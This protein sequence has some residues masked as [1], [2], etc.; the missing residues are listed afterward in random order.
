MLV[1][2]TEKYNFYHNFHDENLKTIEHIKKTD[3][4]NSN[5]AYLICLGQL[6]SKGLPL[7][8][9]SQKRNQICVCNGAVNPH[10][11]FCM[12]KN[13]LVPMVKI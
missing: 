7:Y 12:H 11:K 5:S 9:L 1:A 3:M 4:K 10:G 13:V 8:R 6:N 2:M